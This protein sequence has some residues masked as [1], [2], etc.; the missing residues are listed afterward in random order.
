[1]CGFNAPSRFSFSNFCRQLGLNKIL[2]YLNLA[3][4]DFPI[5]N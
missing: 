4:Y 1:M 2:I 5:A 3:F